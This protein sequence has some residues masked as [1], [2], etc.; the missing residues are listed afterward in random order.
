ML[1]SFIPHILFFIFLQFLCLNHLN[2]I[3]SKPSQFVCHATHQGEHFTA[4]VAD[5]LKST[6]KCIFLHWAGPNDPI[7]L[8]VGKAFFLR[9]CQIV[10]CNINYIHVRMKQRSKFFGASFGSSV[11]FAPSGLRIKNLQKWLLNVVLP[12]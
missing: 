2:K 6:F 5:F 11:C 4:V 10:N 12:P 8:K 9:C 1:Q 3:I 7:F